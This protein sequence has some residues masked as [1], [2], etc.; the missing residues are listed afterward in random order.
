MIENFAEKIKERFSDSIS[1]KYVCDQLILEIRPSDLLLCAKILRDDQSFKFEQLIDICAIDYL[2]YGVSEWET[3]K[4]TCKGFERAVSRLSDKK[5]IKNNN[6]R[7]ALSY[8]LLSITHN[9]RVRL[10]TFLRDDNLKISSVVQI[11]P[12]ANWFERE[13]FDLFGIAF[14]GHPDLR[15]ILTDYG[16][17]G[18][19][20]RKDFPLIGQ[21]EMRYDANKEKCIYEPVSIENRTLIPK[22]IRFVGDEND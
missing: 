11:W 10:K 6:N 1:C 8:E 5:N 7:F 13:A 15:R 12:A 2:H 3:N 17:K 21:L 18:H 16:F 22:T 9:H 4:S 20:F 19:P 14:E